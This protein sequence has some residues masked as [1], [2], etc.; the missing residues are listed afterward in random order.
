MKKKVPAG[1]VPEKEK[2]EKIIKKIKA[3][4]IST[5]KSGRV[6]KKAEKSPS[7]GKTLQ[8]KAPLKISVKKGIVKKKEEPGETKKKIIKKVSPK[9]EK[10]SVKKIGRKKKEEAVSKKIK[11][12]PAGKINAKVTGKGRVIKKEKPEEP[13]VKART[14]KRTSLPQ[15]KKKT[16]PKSAGKPGKEHKAA[17]GSKAETKKKVE[18]G[19]E[20]LAAKKKKIALSKELMKEKIM[21]IFMPEVIEKETRKKKTGKIDRIQGLRGKGIPSLKESKDAGGT[22]KADSQEKD[23]LLPLPLEPLPSEYGENS[24]MLITVNPC[25]IFTFWEVREDTLKISQGILTIRLYD[26]TDIHFDYMD[27][28]SYVDREVSGRIGDMYLDVSPARDYAA[29]IGILSSAGNFITIA[30]SYKVSTPGI[31]APEGFESPAENI[32]TGIR[33]GY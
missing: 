26:I 29:D 13:S 2:T 11:T 28:N 9:K 22:V 24:I 16:V 18:T 27:A 10:P 23:V 4:L 15:A 25:R 32:A 5:S 6:K 31:T 17:S 8:K 14:A 20:Q 33:V 12:I 7:R 3:D 19:K 1:R 30:R 21:G